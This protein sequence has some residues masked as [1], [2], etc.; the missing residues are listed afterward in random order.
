MGVLIGEEG[1]PLPR[2]PAMFD[3][4]KSWS[5]SPPEKQEWCEWQSNYSSTAEH[6]QRVQTQFIEERKLGF[7]LSMSLREA[8]ARFGSRF[9]LTASGAIAK[10]A[11]ATDVRVVL[12]AT[13]RRPDQF[14]DQGP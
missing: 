4:K 10:K 14:R 2:T 9:A 13:Q 8:L 6:A 3:R 5:L 11:I 12:D 7:M 1:R